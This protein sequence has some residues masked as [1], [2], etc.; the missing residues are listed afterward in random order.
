MS[1]PRHLWSGDWEQDSAARAADL[2]AQRGRAPAETEPEPEPAA[3][4]KAQRPT[5]KQRLTAFRRRHGRRLRLALIVGVLA[6]LG[7]GAVIAVADTISGGS[8][9]HQPAAKSPGHAYL[10]VEMI[11]DPSGGVVVSRVIPGSPAQ[12]AGIRPGDEITQID[13]QPIAVPAIA[14]A[15]IDGLRPGDRVEIQMQRGQTTF[16]VH[17]TLAKQPTHHR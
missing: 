12:A 16:T 8:N 1:G 13:T 15:T 7:V 3:V 14:H 5:L 17:V 4:P 2:A 11:S 6:L 10:G 9:N